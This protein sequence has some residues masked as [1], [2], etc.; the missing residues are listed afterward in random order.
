MK[1]SRS[2]KLGNVSYFIP[3]DMQL[4]DSVSLVYEESLTTKVAPAA[5]EVDCAAAKMVNTKA[6]VSEKVEIKDG[7]DVP[8]IWYYFIYFGITEK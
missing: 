7:E 6:S 8:E 3:S 1:W 4:K 5:T 2:H